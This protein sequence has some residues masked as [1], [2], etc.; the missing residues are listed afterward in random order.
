MKLSQTTGIVVAGYLAVSSL[1]SA[2]IMWSS[3]PATV[4]GSFGFGLSYTQFRYG[5]LR[6]DQAEIAADGTIT[7][8][9]KVTNLG[10]CSGKEVVQLYF[11]DVV[12]SVTT[13]VKRLI[14]FDKIELKPG[15]TREVSFSIQAKEL[16]LWNKE[17][18]RVGGWAQG[19][20][21]WRQVAP[22]SSL[23]KMPLLVAK[24]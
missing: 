10:K 5:D 3:T 22:A 18:K 8:R 1:G 16:A 7:A 15:E 23:L 6:L 19:D 17:M 12:S 9:C 14:R 11:R 2:T 13:P 4:S 24:R 21:T 20:R